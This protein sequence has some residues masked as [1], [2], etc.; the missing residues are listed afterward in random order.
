MLLAARFCQCTSRSLAAR[1]GPLVSA[2]STVVGPGEDNR[3]ESPPSPP[4][5]SIQ[6]TGA[7]LQEALAKTPVNDLSDQKTFTKY[8]HPTVGGSPSGLFPF[9][10]FFINGLS[11]CTRHNTYAFC[12]ET[13]TLGR[14]HHHFAAAAALQRVRQRHARSHGVAGNHPCAPNT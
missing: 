9:S 14:E 7:W 10:I 5:P 1:S 12:F 13:H 6:S 8:R 3:F 11:L 4:P 2:F